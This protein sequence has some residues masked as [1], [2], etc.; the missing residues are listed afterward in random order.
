MIHRMSHSEI[1]E[2][3]IVD[4]Y[5][6]Q[7]LSEVQQEQFELHLL[8]CDH[9]QE[10]LEA[11]LSFISGLNA[12]KHTNAV[13]EVREEQPLPQ[14]R[15][16]PKWFDRVQGIAAALVVGCAIILIP[17]MGDQNSPIL[18]KPYGNT[19]NYTHGTLRSTKKLTDIDGSDFDTVSLYLALAAPNFD[20]TLDRQYQIQLTDSENNVFSASL[21]ADE[22]GDAI[23][24]L[25]VEQ[26]AA[27]PITITSTSLHGG[28]NEENRNF[29]FNFVK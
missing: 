1:E 21:T 12:E 17:M 9:C 11:S 4:R 7:Q 28:E 27:G 20:T 2:L 10:S 5:A 22:W 26:L 8:D 3:N 16:M 19:L 24:N 13:T 23:L 6:L 29:L 18:D 14:S 15:P 25:S